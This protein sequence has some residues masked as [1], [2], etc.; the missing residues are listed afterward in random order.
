MP[1]LAIDNG[2]HHGAASD[3]IYDRGAISAVRPGDRWPR[4][5]CKGRR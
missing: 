1:M 4:P 2:G 3:T 5:L